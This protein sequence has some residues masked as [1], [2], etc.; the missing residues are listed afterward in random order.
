MG[1]RCEQR[2]R[3]TTGNLNGNFNTF[4]D[5]NGNQNGGSKQV[6]SGN[7]NYI[8]AVA[9]G[10]LQGGTAY[11]DSS[12]NTIVTP[13]NVGNGNGNFNTNSSSNG[14]LNGNNGQT[15]SG[16]NNTVTGNQIPG[17]SGNG[18][19]NYNAFGQINGNNNTNNVQVVSGNS[20][21]VKA[22]QGVDILAGQA[23]GHGN[24]YTGSN[25]GNNN[26]N[27][28]QYV[29]GSRNTVIGTAYTS[30]NGDTAALANLVP[31]SAGIPLSGGVTSP[32]V[33]NP[34]Y[35]PP[36]QT[37]ANNTDDNTK[38]N[39]QQ[40]TGNDNIVVGKAVNTTVSQL[41]AGQTQG[42]PPPVADTAAYQGINNVQSVSGNYQ[43]QIGN[44][45]AQYIT[46][47]AGQK[48]KVVT[49]TI[50]G[51]GSQAVGFV[52]GTDAQN[53]QQIVNGDHNYVVGTN[54][55]RFVYALDANGNVQTSTPTPGPST[56]ASPTPTPTTTQGSQ[57]QALS[58]QTP[59]V[60][61][62]GFAGG[63]GASGNPTNAAST[64]GSGA[65]FSQTGGGAASGIA[66]GSGA[67][68]AQAA[69]VSTEATMISAGQ[70]VTSGQHVA[71]S[72][73]TRTGS[74]TS[75]TNAGG[76]TDS[77]VVWGRRLLRETA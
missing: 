37:A 73:A 38:N 63:S 72:V 34:N 7:S 61:G 60:A 2:P 35:V 22:Q 77:G 25:N 18:N 27:N 40:V 42:K 64:A 13:N 23:A 28:Q 56:S 41:A 1:H 54:L 15:V 39:Y 26:E 66:A 58:A 30:N 75:V 24:G 45:V 70:T 43:T 49:V 33:A 6:V 21:T 17:Q 11:T 3:N 48:D 29:S 76:R 12:G 5:Y 31:G 51:G 62:D 10:T 65:L 20:N 67:G 53:N 36:P 59:W 8:S 14:N 4:G 52:A 44:T 32:V 71:A 16:T 68:S 57:P 55:H 50:D 74:L 19:G 46:K 47:Q 9:D 69:R